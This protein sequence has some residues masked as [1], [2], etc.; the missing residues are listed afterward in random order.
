MWTEKAGIPAVGVDCYGFLDSARTAALYEGMPDVRLFTYP[1][2]NIAVESDEQIVAKAKLIFDDVVKMLTVE[3]PKSGWTIPRLDPKKTVVSGAFDEVNQFFYDNKWTDG[4]PIIPPTIAK[5]EEFLKYTDYAPDK[6]L[7]VLDPAKCE[8]TPWN[9]AV[10]G[11]MAGCRPEYMPI[12]MAIARLG[13][14][15]ST[16]TFGGADLWIL[17]GPIRAQL[18]FNSGQGVLAPGTKANITVGRFVELFNTNVKGIIIGTT[19][20]ACWG[21]PTFGILAESE[22]KSPW[23]SL[24]VDKGF[25]PGANVIHRASIQTLTGAMA[26]EGEADQ[27]VKGIAQRAKGLGYTYTPGNGGMVFIT[28]MTAGILDKGGVKK[29]DLQKYLF[30][31]TKMTSAEEQ[32]A[33]VFSGKI[34]MNDYC[35]L[36]KDGKLAPA[37]TYC[38]S[39]PQKL[40]PISPSPDDWTIVVSGDGERNRHIIGANYSKGI[41]IELPKKWDELIKALGS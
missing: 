1:Y 3:A 5:V 33:F 19:R 27:Q 41:E 16:S 8:V 4:L 40:V 37:E 39:D 22:E 32:Q 10:N 14:G 9:V 34:K 23:T 35:A 30:E 15:G 12:L 13:G 36:V 28:P 21:L 38:P 2:P 6:V 26:T 29:K 20:M 31:N 25:K 17:N 18:G 11:V 7:G 24:S